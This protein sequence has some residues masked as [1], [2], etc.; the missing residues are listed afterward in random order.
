MTEK[1][2]YASYLKD[3][4]ALASYAP[5]KQ[6]IEWI[7]DGRIEDYL[8]WEL[9]D[10]YLAAVGE[11]APE[12]IERDRRRALFSP[13]SL[14]RALSNARFRGV[15][16]SKRSNGNL[17]ARSTISHFLESPMEIA[18][19]SGSDAAFERCLAAWASPVRRFSDLADFGCL[20]V[21]SCPYVDFSSPLIDELIEIARGAYWDLLIIAFMVGRPDRAEAMVRCGMCPTDNMEWAS[22]HDRVIKWKRADSNAVTLFAR[23]DQ[24]DWKPII[25][26]AWRKVELAQE[27]DEELERTRGAGSLDAMAAGKIISD[28]VEKGASIGYMELAKATEWGRLDLL[29]KLFASGGDPNIRYKTGVSTLARMNQDKLTPEALQVWL[30]AGANP[31]FCREHE[32]V[33]VSKISL[34]ALYNFVWAGRL[35]LVQTCCDTSCGPVALSCNWNGA[36]YSPFLAVALSKGHKDLAVWMITQKGCKLSDLDP[37]TG[38]P[39][40]ELASPAVL[41]EVKAE[42]QRIAMRGNRE[43][44]AGKPG[45]GSIRV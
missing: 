27:L 1:K 33:E 4:A 11:P 2:T 20:D 43:I 25:D 9:S 28:F 40:R 5:R 45:K 10:G 15:P 23:V 24:V 13:M 36:R 7:L 6:A 8:D 41:D 31:M 39:C 44:L 21:I 14:D 12:S 30:E 16:T 26:W 29:R 42:V 35:D 3:I 19:R 34:G 37:D 17:A 18:L 22:F 32:I 38:S